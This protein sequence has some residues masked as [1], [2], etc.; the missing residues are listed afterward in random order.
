[1]TESNDSN[2]VSR[3]TADG[4]PSFK[5]HCG[6]TGAVA[7]GGASS[8]QGGEY[9]TEDEWRA[10]RHPERVEDIVDRLMTKVSGGRAAPATLLRGAWSDV[11]GDS[12]AAKTR[13]GSC[14]S[15]RLVVLVADGATA[16]KMRFHT[17]LIMQKAVEVAGEGS[18]SSIVFRVSPDLRR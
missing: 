18:V 6:A 10:R 11:V 13:P 16:S 12:F 15:G 14:E 4:G 9:L 2:N 7:E 5:S 8:Y 3:S 17:S 1:M